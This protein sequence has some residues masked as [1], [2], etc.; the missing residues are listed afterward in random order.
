MEAI[1]GIFLTFLSGFVW[2]ENGKL[3]YPSCF[4]ACEC[5]L[6]FSDGSVLGSCGHYSLDG[7]CN[8]FEHL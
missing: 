1:L 2:I 7:E 5:Y 6:F 8:A 3:E 4:F